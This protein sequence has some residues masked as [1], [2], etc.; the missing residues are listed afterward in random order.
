MPPPLSTPRRRRSKGPADAVPLRAEPVLAAPV[1]EPPPA[2]PAQLPVAEGMP[3]AAEN[4]PPA[5]APPIILPEGQPWM[6]PVRFDNLALH[7]RRKH[8]MNRWV[9]FIAQHMRRSRQAE[10]AAIPSYA[11]KKRQVMAWAREATANEEKAFWENKWRTEMNVPAYVTQV[12]FAAGA[13]PA[14]YDP[15]AW[16]Q[17]AFVTYNNAT[18][19]VR[20]E[21]GE[22]QKFQQ[23]DVDAVAE[24]A[25]RSAV[26][27]DLMVKMS[28]FVADFRASFSSTASAFALEICPRTLKDHPF[29]AMF[30]I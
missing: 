7:H 5:E 13:D 25:K 10:L 17:M 9:N 26:A 28:A 3:N 30:L 14:E 12:L 24:I 1:V 6:D 23:A 2:A 27:R 19:F 11:E 21:H 16:V 15:T 29:R 4:P 18:W 8:A 20:D 22:A